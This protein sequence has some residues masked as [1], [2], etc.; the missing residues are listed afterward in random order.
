MTSRDGKQALCEELE[1]LRRFAGIN[2]TDELQQVADA[3]FQH[4]VGSVVFHRAETDP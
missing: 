1:T 2:Q 3:G 4:D